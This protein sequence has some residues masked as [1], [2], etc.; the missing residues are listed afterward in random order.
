M[1]T[2]KIER[3]E[4]RP[5]WRVPA[6][7]ERHVS[8]PVVPAKSRPRIEG[9]E[10]EMQPVSSNIEDHNCL[11]PPGFWHQRGTMF[12]TRAAHS[13]STSKIGGSVF[14]SRWNSPRVLLRFNCFAS[15]RP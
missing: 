7:L 1:N 9:R 8:P 14:E 3:E 2:E 13:T 10:N 5:E 15:T 4:N 6:H 12:F 11:S